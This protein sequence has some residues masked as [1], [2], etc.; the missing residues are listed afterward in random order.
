[1]QV[2]QNLY[3]GRNCFPWQTVSKDSALQQYPLGSFF[4]DRYGNRFEYAL[5]GSGALVAGDI[6]QSPP[7]GGADTTL[8]NP[9]SVS[10]ASLVYETRIYCTALTTAQ[11]AN[12]FA[13]GWAAFYDAS[14]VAAYTRRIKGNSA[15][16]TTGVASYIDIET[17]LPVALTVSDRIALMANP[18]SNIIQVPTS[19]TGLIVGGVSG[20]VTAAYYCWVQTWG[21]FGTHIKDGN[22]A[23]GNLKNGGSTAGTLAAYGETDYSQVVALTNGAWADEYAGMV[24]LRCQA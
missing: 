22:L 21:W 7:L 15:L 20:A 24:F 19:P 16:L 5:N 8:Q 23:I 9:A 17:P 6:V 2:D 11:V 10:V 1:M 3:L 13:E 12:V 18:M 4:Y 14:L